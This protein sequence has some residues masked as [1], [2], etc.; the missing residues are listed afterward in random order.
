MKGKSAFEERLIAFSCESTLK[1]AKQLLKLNRIKGAFRDAEGR[2]HA[3][4]SDKSGNI[5][6]TVKPGEPPQSEC[7]CSAA[8]ALAEGKVCDHALALLMYSGQFRLPEQSAE[9]DSESA[10]YT[11]LKNAGLETLSKECIPQPEAE[12]FIQAESAFPHVP[13]K[14]ENAVL[15]VRL[16]AD[17]REY[18]GNLNN[19]R[20]LFFDKTLAVTLKLNQFSLQD[21]QIIRFLAINGEADS[22]NIL[23]NS[24]QT[25]ELFHCLGDFER[26]FRNGRR[27]IIHTE[28]NARAVILVKHGSAGR[29]YAPGIRFRG[30]LL[31]IHSAKVITG[32]SGCWVGKGGE[33]F[34]VAADCEIGFLRNFFRL[35][36][37]SDATPGSE[38]FLAHPPLECVKYGKD[39]TPETPDCAILLE[40]LL[41]S[42]K[43]SLELRFVY[44]EESFH[45]DA[46][47]MVPGTRGR[48]W[49]RQEALETDVVNAFRM[50]G[51]SGDP[52]QGRFELG[53]PET[54]GLFLDSVLPDWLGKYP[55]LVLG[56]ALSRLAAGGNGLP[57]IELSCDATDAI[58]AA[59]NF[60]F[61]YRWHD[62]R[63]GETGWKNLCLA[64]RNQARYLLLDNGMPAALPPA[65]ART[66][67]KLNGIIQRLDES[68]H[69]FAL[70]RVMLNYYHYLTRQW[71]EALPAALARHV[72]SD[73]PPEAPNIVSTPPIQAKL[74]PY[75]QQ[76]VD[77]LRRMLGNG[78]NVI[79]A[80]EMGLGKTVQALAALNLL[81]VAGAPPALVVCPA[82]LV[83]NWQRE[84]NRF[85]PAYKV[86]ALYG[87]QRDTVLGHL[88]DYD[89][90]VVSYTLA[91]REIAQL[92]KQ[93]FTLVIL[94][95][96]QHIKNPGTANAQSCKALKARHK[97]VLTGTPLE[98][99]PDDLWSI[100]D[101][102]HPGL[103]GSFNSFK[104]TYAD[105]A[106]SPEL[107]SEL[108]ARVAPFIKRRNKAMVAPELP[109]REECSCFCT[110]E[111]AQR[112]LYDQM[113][114]EGRKQLAHLEQDPAG[115]SRGNFEILT[116]LLRLRQICCHPALLGE[117]KSHADGESAKFELLQELVL[118]HLD[119]HHKMLLFSQFTSLLALV[120]S[121]LNASGIRYCYLD[122]AT[123]NRQA[124][125]DEF[126]DTPE[127]PIFLL[128]LKA[129]G[130]GLNLTSADTV[131]IYDPWWNPAAEL[132]AADRTHRIGQTRPVRILKLLVNDSIEE[133]ILRL[134]EKKREIFDQVVDNPALATEKLTIDELKFLLK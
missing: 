120:R 90:V 130:T 127:I 118:E 28:A 31:E 74:R 98:N 126:N 42:E 50:L 77:W 68:S 106:G 36:I 121:W 75:Q 33:Y 21:R 105:I 18:L 56:G 14:W 44:D 26:F 6:V 103:L 12:V 134:Q 29:E 66:V 37:W 8:A 52:A 7:D 122:G 100:F 94:D 131:M 93:Y 10:Q 81:R 108:A 54:I 128:S 95:E 69:S 88:T 27:L 104:K 51:A 47:R 129:G 57:A 99:S 67:Q 39:A 23:L 70:P 91:R 53:E 46:G 84:C 71:P 101:F 89:L 62:R 83:E 43:L 34:W 61:C 13:S 123:R 116:T 5:H 87:S 79:L 110:M 60:T 17:K 107:Q 92:S 49:L 124:V 25:A 2:L 111:P 19:L 15:S 63:G 35:G 119:S 97:L 24:E 65:V 4:I 133:K 114:A 11:G 30:A 16:R 132:Q 32:R 20:Q 3:V 58:D 41:A 59:D 72:F 85:L 115:S 48:F 1:Q 78:F 38:S 22:S 125:V 73:T 80:D 45:P 64:A 76:G 86:G 96:A 109:P 40:G 9:I 55:K 102:L 112:A 117:N 113:L 82:S